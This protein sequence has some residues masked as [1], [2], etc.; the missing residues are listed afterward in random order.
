MSTETKG[1]TETK[2]E[3]TS[4]PARGY[5]GPPPWELATKH[6]LEHDEHR[7]RAGLKTDDQGNLVPSGE[8]PQPYRGPGAVTHNK[9]LMAQG[10]AGAD[11]AELAR[12]LGV[13]GYTANSIAKGTNHANVLDDSV[14]ND[15]VQFQR[16]HGVYEN[17]ASFSGGSVPAQDMVGRHVGPYTWQALIELSDRAEVEAAQSWGEHREHAIFELAQTLGGGALR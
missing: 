11:V 12:R 1:K 16:D 8:V 4:W 6:L 10:T 5:D 7:K 2:G 14:W 9:P 17:E 3:A 15:V 13:L